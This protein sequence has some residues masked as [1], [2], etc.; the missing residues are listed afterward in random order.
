MPASTPRPHARAGTGDSKRRMACQVT[1]LLR[2]RET[3]HAGGPP[4]EKK[5]SLWC[6]CESPED[7]SLP[8][9]LSTACSL[10]TLGKAEEADRVGLE[11]E[12]RWAFGSSRT[13][14]HSVH[15]EREHRKDQCPCMRLCLGSK[16]T[17]SKRGGAI[18]LERR[19]TDRTRGKTDRRRSC[20]AEER[21][22]TWN[23][24]SRSNTI[25]NE[26]EFTR[27]GDPCK[28]EEDTCTYRKNQL[29]SEGNGRA[30]RDR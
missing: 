12:E 11:S 18:A 1:V 16:D 24:S 19:T 23:W 27:L 10:L 13:G 28:D 21:V 9:Y 3:L 8:F 22:P 7:L 2:P 25:E 5:A 6:M 15:D 29:H 26:G 14:S 4:H 17:P 20:T 30:I